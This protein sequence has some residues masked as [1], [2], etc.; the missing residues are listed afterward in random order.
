MKKNIFAFC[1]IPKAGGT[2]LAN[3]LK[4][5]YTSDQIISVGPIKNSLN[6]KELKA[7]KSEYF[8]DKKIILGVH[9]KFG[10]HKLITPNEVSVKYFTFLREP[11]SRIVS[12]Y[13]YIKSN[14][15]HQH[16]NRI[17]NNKISL[18]EFV[19]S[20][21]TLELDNWMIRQLANIKVEDRQVNQEHLVKCQ[22]ILDSHFAL[23]GIM[24][25]FNDDLIKLADILNWDSPPFYLKANVNKRKPKKDKISPEVLNSIQERNKYDIRLYN[26]ILNLR[27]DSLVDSKTKEFEIKNRLY[28]MPKT[29]LIDLIYKYE[30]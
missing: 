13:Y 2:T 16:Y 15:N 11:V 24:E 6:F 23:V 26:N 30:R 4:S 10:I 8:I 21:M 25:N 12:L 27:N 28:N 18:K 14:P 5:Q 7:K 29:K 20:D 17:I 3:I 9:F 19:N 22:E 1:H